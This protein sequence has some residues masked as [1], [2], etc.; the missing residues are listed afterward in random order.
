M[1][2]PSYVDAHILATNA[3]KGQYRKYNGLPY[4]THPEAVASMFE[5]QTHKIVAILHDIIEDTPTTIQ[6]LFNLN[7]PDEILC[8]VAAITKRTHQPYLDYILRVQANPI[9]T[10]V[11][12]QDIR[13]NLSTLPTLPQNKDKIGKY[14][15]ALHILTNGI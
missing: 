6:D 1:T 4:I 11:K 2:T 14:N 13:H 12:I 8:A 10:S 15:L 3:H 5:T 7:Y 9:A